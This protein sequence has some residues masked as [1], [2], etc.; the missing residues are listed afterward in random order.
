MDIF[1]PVA[2]STF[3]V[4]DAFLKYRTTYQC[5][6]TIVHPTVRNILRLTLCPFYYSFQEG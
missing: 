4:K 5:I 2:G 6:V 1:H 3:C